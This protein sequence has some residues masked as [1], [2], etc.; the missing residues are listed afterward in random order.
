M[1]NFPF[2]LKDNFDMKENFPSFNEKESLEKMS[3]FY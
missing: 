2:L 1:K 3:L